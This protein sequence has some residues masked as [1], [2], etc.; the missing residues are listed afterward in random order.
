MLPLPLQLTVADSLLLRDMLLV[1]LRVQDLDL[2]PEA[3]TVMLGVE[4]KVWLQ[5]TDRLWLR[6]RLL[7]SVSLKLQEVLQLPEVLIDALIVEDSVL[8]S[9]ELLV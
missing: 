5:D 3:E 1:K 6:L 4:E 8:L 9:L 7:D 2:L